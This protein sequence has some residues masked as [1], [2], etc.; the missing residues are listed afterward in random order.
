[1]LRDVPIPVNVSIRSI[2][3]TLN[4]S[5]VCGPS[6]G[7]DMVLPLPALREFNVLSL[8]KKLKLIL[9]V[10]VNDAINDEVEPSAIR[11]C[12]EVPPVITSELA[13]MLP[14]TCSLEAGVVVPIPTIPV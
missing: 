9:A 13:V 1:M 3:A 2:A 7:N 5:V 6:I 12:E 14:F 10:F 4:V 11:Y 8:L